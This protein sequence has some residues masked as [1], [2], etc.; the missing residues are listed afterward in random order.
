METTS[1]VQEDISSPPDTR[2]APAR[3]SSG[4]RP[5]DRR[6][7]LTPYGLA[8]PALLVIV[9]LTLAP[10]VYGV[11]LSFTDWQFL[12]STSPHWEGLA[13]FRAVVD[14][15]AFWSA[16]GHT[17][18]WTIGTVAIELCIGLPLG[19]LLS[20]PTK[21]SGLM[22]A[23]LLLP[24]VTPFV[25]VAYSWL[26]LLGTGGPVHSLLQAVGLV[27]QSSP[28]AS[29]RLALPVITVISG[30]KGLPFMAVALLAA[31]RGIDD[32]LYEAAEVDG[33]GPTQRFRR[34]TLPLLRN[35]MIVMSVVLGVLAFYSF[36]LVWLLTQG[37]PG[38][39]STLSGVLIYQEFF[40]NGAPGIAA[41]MG[42]SVFVILLVVSSF[43]LSITR[44]NRREA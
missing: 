43:L 35:V 8:A 2:R 11:W 7:A 9:A 12:N 1:V 4:R 37:G 20:R 15:S 13:G 16:F 14:S 10:A 36:D 3:G 39:S 40:L 6:R 34:I 23:L 21:V 24:W 17:W 29:T 5:G 28:L 19:L 44:V 38:T 31:R 42:I 30:W 26:Y 18:F 41:A 25:V 33:A 27:G 22:T 32:T